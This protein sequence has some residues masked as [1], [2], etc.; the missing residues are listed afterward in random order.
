MLV[1]LYNIRQALGRC[2]KIGFL[3]YAGWSHPQALWC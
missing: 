1:H 2:V 3:A